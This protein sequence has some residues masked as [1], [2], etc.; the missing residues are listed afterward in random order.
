MPKPFQIFIAYSRKDTPYLEEL[1]THL[2][3]LERSGKVRIWYDGKIEPGAVWEQAIKENLH[4]ADIILLMVSADAINSDYFYEKEMADALARHHAGEARVVPLIVRSCLWQ[5]TPLKDLQALPKDGLPVTSWPIRDDAYSDAV[6]SLW[7]MIEN[8]EQVQREEQERLLR[9][10]EARR[11]QETA[12]AAQKEA[13]RQKLLDEQRAR[14]VTDRQRQLEAQRQKDA[15]EAERRRKTEAERQQQLAEQRKK[16]AG[17]DRQRKAAAARQREQQ[18][19]AVGRG[20]RSPWA[21]G[22][23]LALAALFIFKMW[24]CNGPDSQLSTS[25]TGGDTT[26]LVQN[27]PLDTQQG[28]T[29]ISPQSL[30]P[31]VTV[32]QPK[33]AEKKTSSKP[34]EEE[35]QSEKTTSKTKGQEEKI[36]QPEE[37]TSKTQDQEE[38]KPETSNTSSF[39]DPF[40]DDMVRIASGN[41]TMGCT[42]EQG[43]DCD[44]N[45]K[46]PHG[47]TVRDYYLCRYEV[48][49]AQW[50]AV[51]GSDPSKF[52]FKGCDNCPVEG[53]SWN[54]V[55]EFIKK[56]NQLTGKKYRLPTEAEW[57]Y[58]ARGGNKS[59]GYKYAGSNNL[60]EVAWYRFN[61]GG[62]THPVGKKKKN[63]LGLYDMSGNVVEWCQDTWHKNYDG[64]PKDGSAWTT[65]DDQ[66]FRE[67]RG[68]WWDDYP[69]GCRAANRKRN[70]PGYRGEVGF[71]VAQD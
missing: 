8:F 26:T 47:V 18:M 14:Q 5:A 55:Q 28:V 37:N 46:P 40:A 32:A 15:A 61:S 2:N 42:P 64:A 10:Q 29:K 36:T 3:P 39:Q 57:E 71:R 58:A 22:S 53:V 6:G 63:E 60:G 1:R 12:F 65:G 35:K 20:L 66:R 51:I 43:S 17:I 4:R 31:D 44:Y 68:G 62:K 70:T 24:I 54:D 56:L 49:Q 69:N 9:E 7:T 11:E 16:Q 52:K 50:R 19:A 48:T 27:G 30:P 67:Y 41:F 33:Q 25:Q 34:A 23:G 45:E 13:E 38:K 59:N 21:W